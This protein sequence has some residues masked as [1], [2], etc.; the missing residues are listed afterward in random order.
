MSNQEPQTKPD[1]GA[2]VS[3]DGLGGVNRQGEALLCYAWG[4][5]DRPSVMIARTRDEVQHFIVAEWLGVEDAIDD[6]FQPEL[7]KIMARI[8]AHDWHD[9]ALEWEFEIGG[10]R[11]EDV[12]MTPNDLANAPASTGD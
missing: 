1:G 8:D 10:V 7:P 12:F 3:T 11:L 9:G 2:S 5:T 4:E 6:D